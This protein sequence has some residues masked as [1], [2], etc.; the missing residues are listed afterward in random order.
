MT[1]EQKVKAY[2]EAIK[3]AEATIKVAQNQKEVYGCITTIF[4]ELKESEDERIRKEI[5]SIV[6][7][8]RECCITKGNHRF[9]DCIAWLEKQGKKK[10]SYATIVES[11]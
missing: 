6:K 3:R 10:A 11:K 7:S 2:D 1:Q 8:Y 4:P 9:D 5:I